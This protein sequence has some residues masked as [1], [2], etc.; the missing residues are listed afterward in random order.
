MSTCN[1]KKDLTY[2]EEITEWFIENNFYSNQFFINNL[3][4][5][6]ALNFLSDYK[7]DNLRLK[8]NVSVKGSYSD[9]TG[10]AEWH[11]GGDDDILIGLYFTQSYENPIVELRVRTNSIKDDDTG[12]SLLDGVS[13]EKNDNY[14]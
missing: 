14:K 12:K 3:A 4:F 8:V 2:C 10:D 5:A 7:K 13:C 9:R 11:E 1:P 6:Y